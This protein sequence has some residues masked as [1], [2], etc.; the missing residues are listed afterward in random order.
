MMLLSSDVFVMV[1]TLGG[2]RAGSEGKGSLNVYRCCTAF[3]LV[4]TQGRTGR[5]RTVEEVGP[6]S[7]CNVWRV[8]H[9]LRGL[10]A[11]LVS[12]TSSAFTSLVGKR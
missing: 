11:G 5:A 8:R 3:R 6:R 12:G 9:L 10:L 4:S 1:I 7:A 2:L